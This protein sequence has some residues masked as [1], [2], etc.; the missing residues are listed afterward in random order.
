MKRNFVSGAVMLLL[1]IACITASAQT[2]PVTPAAATPAPQPTASANVPDTKIALVDTAM[3]GDARSG[4]KRYLNA[5]SSVQLQFKPKTQELVDLQTRMKTI[6]DEITRLN[7]NPVVDP[8]S[9]QAKQEEGERL[10][11]DFKYKKEQLDADFEKRYNEIVGPVS[12]DIGKAL[13][14]Y[15]SQHGL[16]MILDISKLLPAILTANPAMDITTPFIAE[17]NSRNP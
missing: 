9:I 8:K 12:A 2:R 7:G 13:D 15:A 3:F 14:Q 16:T 5:V 6:A 4:I 17:Y 10:Q 1:S 11:R